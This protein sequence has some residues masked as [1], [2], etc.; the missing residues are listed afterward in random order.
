M[1]RRTVNMV[2]YPTLM[3][4]TFGWNQAHSLN[5][6]AQREAVV[7]LGCFK[8]EHPIRVCGSARIHSHGSILYYLAQ[9][10]QADRPLLPSWNFKHDPGE[11]ERC[12]AE[13]LN[14]GSL[15]ARR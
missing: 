3:G 6:T 8:T 11:K 4:R 14:L 10:D 7:A 5:A 2:E 9:L 12:Q 15:A 1:R 13:A